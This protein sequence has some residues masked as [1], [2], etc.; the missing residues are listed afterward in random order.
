MDP[1]PAQRV[2]REKGS[3]CSRFS[4]IGGSLPTGAGHFKGRR[5][6]R[7]GRASD[8]SHTSNS[9]SNQMLVQLGID[10]SGNAVRQSEAAALAAAAG[11][12]SVLK[13]LL[14]CTAFQHLHLVKL[15]PQLFHGVVAVLMLGTFRL[16]AGHNPRGLMGNAHS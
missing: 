6:R 15:C 5:G 4:T 13:R 10:Q 2:M 12:T 8:N 14:F 16:A 9:K 3:M 1:N 7:K 11:S